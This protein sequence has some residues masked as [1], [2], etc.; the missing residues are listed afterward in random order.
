[1]P[2]LTSSCSSTTIV[3]K[4]L[5][6]ES[7]RTALEAVF[8]L[9]S[10][11]RNV[12]WKMKSKRNQIN[13]LIMSNLSRAAIAGSGFDLYFEGGNPILRDRDPNSSCLLANRNQLVSK[14]AFLPVGDNGNIRVQ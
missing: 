12:A 10:P 13:M 9:R 3:F 6:E 14:E 4:R 11:L 1:M 8:V 7:T 5:C 2:G